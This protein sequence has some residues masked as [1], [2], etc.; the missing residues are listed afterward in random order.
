MP[1]ALASENNLYRLPSKP[2]AYDAGGDGGRGLSHVALERLYYVP[3]LPNVLKGGCTRARGCG[4]GW[5]GF[6]RLQGLAGGVMAP[7]ATCEGQTYQ[8]PLFVPRW[9][10]DRP[11][12]GGVVSTPFR[13]RAQTRGRACSSVAAG[14]H[15][16]DLPN[17]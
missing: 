6:V 11:L 7:S 2:R 16:H 15:G 1:G 4:T 5:M 9:R 10:T 12:E 13:Q 14:Q 17:S 3:T 8:V